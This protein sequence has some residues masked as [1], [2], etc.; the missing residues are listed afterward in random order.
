MMLHTKYQGSM[1]CDFR[2]EYFSPFFYLSL[3][4]ISDPQGEAIFG[5]RGIIWKKKK[6]GRGPLGEASYQI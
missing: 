2:Q 4:K 5:P 3:C 6:V 1:P